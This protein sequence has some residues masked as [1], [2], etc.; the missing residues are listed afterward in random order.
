[1]AHCLTT[2]PG[3]GAHVRRDVPQD[4]RH[5]AR[6]DGLLV[7]RACPS[8]SVAPVSAAQLGTPN[9]WLLVRPHRQGARCEQRLSFQNTLLEFV[10]W[11]INQTEWLDPQGASYQADPKTEFADYSECVYCLRNLPHTEQQ[12]EE[13]LDLPSLKFY[14]DGISPD[15]PDGQW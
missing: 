5:P 3:T 10:Q 4:A 7:V 1:M 14:D 6:A 11:V 2:P 13:Q 9:A 12:H 8:E 15:P